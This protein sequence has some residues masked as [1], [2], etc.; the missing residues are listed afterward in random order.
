MTNSDIKLN[1]TS[2]IGIELHSSTKFDMPHWTTFF[3]NARATMNNS[4]LSEIKYCESS[5]D[6][7]RDIDNV[8]TI[9]GSLGF[10]TSIAVGATLAPLPSIP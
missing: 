7:F 2:P 1:A 6:K 9:V 3:Y 4:H 10:V 5:N 8:N